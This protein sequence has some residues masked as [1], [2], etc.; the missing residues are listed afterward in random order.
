[1]HN[2]AVN[3][4]QKNQSSSKNDFSN[5][6]S[7]NRD[8]SKL[9]Q[10]SNNGNNFD[11]IVCQSEPNKTFCPQARILLYIGGKPVTYILMV[12]PIGD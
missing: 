4:A 7:F 3:F 11:S 10:T 5:Q 12:I 1:M 9:G 2:L 8:M 6:N